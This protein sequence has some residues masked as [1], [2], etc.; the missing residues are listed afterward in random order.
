MLPPDTHDPSC[1]PH[2][3]SSTDGNEHEEKPR[4]DELKNDFPDAT[5]DPATS[6][7]LAAHR[8]FLQAED[9]R[10]KQAAEASK[11][12]LVKTYADINDICKL[13]DLKFELLKLYNQKDEL[14]K[15]TLAELRRNRAVRLNA[16]QQLAAKAAQIVQETSQEI[17]Q[18]DTIITKRTTP[19]NF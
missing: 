3:S 6:P 9:A 12:D 11:K 2:E 1:L 14:Q 17:K 4:L 7:L 8:A 5:Q 19:H 10:V 15:K 13:M 16:M 18:L